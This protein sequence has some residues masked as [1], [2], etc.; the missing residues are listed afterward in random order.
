ML[1]EQERIR[2]LRPANSGRRIRREQRTIEAMIGIYCRDHHQGHG[3]HCDACAD[4]LRYARQRLDN[5]VFGE[6]K[7][8]CTHCSVHCYS[9]KLRTRIIDV[10]RY[11]G[12]RM[13]LRHPYLAL[14]H[15]LD[16]LRA[17]RPAA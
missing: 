9:K 16:K 11:A 1:T 17:S 12:P 5:C 14:M 7:M 4:L 15:M 8:P 10:M 13:G 6:S 2:R 3:H